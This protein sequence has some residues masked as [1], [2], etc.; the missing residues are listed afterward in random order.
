MSIL[1]VDYCK[2][3]DK[4]MFSLKNSFLTMNTTRYTTTVELQYPYVLQSIRL[5]WDIRGFVF[6][7]ID[8]T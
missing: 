2:N 6:S 5:I 1:V 4:N 8:P 7:A 3:D